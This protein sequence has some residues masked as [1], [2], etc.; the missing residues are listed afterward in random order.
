RSRGPV[1][2]EGASLVGAVGA[3]RLPGDIAAVARAAARTLAS[4]WARQRAAGHAA[5]P[6]CGVLHDGAVSGLT[7]RQRRL[8][9][10]G[11]DSDELRDRDLCPSCRRA[12]REP[13]V[14]AAARR[15]APAPNEPH[16][17]LTVDEG[18]AARRLAG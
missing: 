11:R 1:P 14:I 9:E 15:L 6:T 8:A 3:P 2:G 17:E 18:A 16:P 5:C 13:R 4:H 7:P 12:A 10:L